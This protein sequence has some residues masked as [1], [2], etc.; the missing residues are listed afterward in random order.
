MEGSV[1]RVFCTLML[2]SYGVV[3]CAVKHGRR[4]SF[5]AS[6]VH[7]NVSVNHSRYP[8]YMMQLYQSF[9]TAD[10]SSEVTSGVGD[11]SL[12][13]SDSVLSLTAGGE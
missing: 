1:L 10:S 5:R 8:L 12:Q 11:E 7:R 9:R 13:G 4:A 6:S 3:F 2:C